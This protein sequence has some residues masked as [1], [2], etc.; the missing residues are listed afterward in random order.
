MP[1]QGLPLHRYRPGQTGVTLIELLIG[2]TIGLLVVVAAVGSLV[3]T[4]TSSTTVGDSTRLQQDA[5][6]AFRVLGHQIRQGGARRIVNSPASANVVFNE[7]YGGFGTN[8]T[9]AST[10]VLRGTDGAAG[11]TDTLEMS[12]DTDPI[13][14]STDCLGEPSA[15]A[16]SVTSTFS[17]NNGELRCQGSGPAAEFAILQ[18]V[19]DFQ[20]TYGFRTGDDLQYRT[21]TAITAVNPA[22]WDQVETVQ[23]CL[24]LA[25]ELANNPGADVTGCSGENVAADG[26]IRR[27]FLRVFNIRNQGL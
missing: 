2:I 14:Q 19:E 7:A 23:I 13:L 9:T 15:V 5:A 12:H 10:I 16:N 18:G 8:T 4:R 21:A 22:P 26:R 3:Y 25:G 1:P 24:R 6:N 20:V 27:V 11:A 17:V